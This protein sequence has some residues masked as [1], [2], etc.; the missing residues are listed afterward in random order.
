MT[1]GL[2]GAISPFTNAWTTWTTAPLFALAFAAGVALPRAAGRRRSRAACRTTRARGARSRSA[3]CCSSRRSRCGSGWPERVHYTFNDEYEYLDHAQRLLDDRRVPPV[4]RSAGGRLRSYALA[5]ALLGASNGGAF[6]LTI[7]L[8]SLTPPVLDVVLRVSASDRTVSLVAAAL[9]VVTPLHVKHAASAS[10]EIPSLL[11]LLLV[12]GHVRGA[13]A[14]T[15][16]AQRRRAR[17]VPLPRADGARRELGARRRC[18]RWSRGCCAARRCV[19]ARGRWRSSLVAAALAALYL[20]GI[21]DAPIRY[22]RGGRAGC[23][24]PSCC[25]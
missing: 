23:R 24:R 9:L 22:T 13:A 18:C 12:L 20:P 4:D 16:L 3:S 1:T 8:A 17:G 14:R 2:A 21:L 6:L 10:I 19:R 11:L 7:V 5:F 15:D 25:S